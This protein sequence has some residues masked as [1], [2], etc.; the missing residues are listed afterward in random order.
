MIEIVLPEGQARLYARLALQAGGDVPIEE[1]YTA[2]L[3]RDEPDRPV[4]N[5]QQ[6]L[7]SYITRL[8]R[9]LRASDIA[10]KPGRVKQTYRLVSTK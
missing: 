1:L 5:K 9:R 3:G 2:V 7:G 10:V 4:R 6:V 8:N